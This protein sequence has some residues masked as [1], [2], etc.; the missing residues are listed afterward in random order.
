MFRPVSPRVRTEYYLGPC[1]T[2][3]RMPPVCRSP[4]DS[5]LIRYYFYTIRGM[6][7]HHCCLL[8]IARLGYF[9]FFFLF[10]SELL[11]RFFIYICISIDTIFCYFR[12]NFLTRGAE[13]I[14]RR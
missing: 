13:L 1:I 12:T 3:N 14:S 4:S 9:S 7:H 10:T 6:M 8:I 5:P 11:T 2:R